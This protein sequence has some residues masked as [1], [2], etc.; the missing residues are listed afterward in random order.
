MRL[1]SQCGDPREHLYEPIR[2]AVPQSG[3]ANETCARCLGP[4]PSHRRA[5]ICL[6]SFFVVPSDAERLLDPRAG[7]SSTGIN[8]T[9][10]LRAAAKWSLPKDL[11]RNPQTSVIDRRA[12]LPSACVLR[13]FALDSVLDLGMQD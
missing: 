5:S 9:P 8:A 13:E 1:L 10:E 12:S 4:V 3:D 7:R 2:L 11:L 6:P